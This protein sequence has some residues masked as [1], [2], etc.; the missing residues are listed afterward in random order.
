ME[1]GKTELKE[2]RKRFAYYMKSIETDF[3]VKVELG[4]ITYDASEFRTKMTV[5]NTANAAGVA[6]NTDEV[7]YNKYRMIYGLPEFGSP[8]TVHGKTCRVC[9]FK[10]RST[11][12]PVIVE[13]P[14][15]KKYKVTIDEVK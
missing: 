1:M 7:T 9:G 10:P 6:V 11:K 4:N 8:V 3:G 15:G 14:N 2:F 12:Y 5:R 13:Y